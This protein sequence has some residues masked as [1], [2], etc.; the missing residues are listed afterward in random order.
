VRI[1]AQRYN[2]LDEYTA[3]ATALAG[4][5]LGPAKPRGL[6]GRLRR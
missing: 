5:L 4:R 2:Q 1:S 3:L 6:L